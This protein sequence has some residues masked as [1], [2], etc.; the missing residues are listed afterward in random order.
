MEDSAVGRFQWNRLGAIS[1][2][3]FLW[4]TTTAEGCRRWVSSAPPTAAPSR[5]REQKQR[6]QNQQNHHHQQQ[7]TVSVFWDLDNKPPKRVSPFEAAIRLKEMAGR[8][9]D[10]VDLVAYANHHAFTYVPTWIHEERRQRKV[11]DLL[12]STG[13]VKPNEPYVC[14]VCGAKK[15]THVQLTKHFKMLHEREQKKRMNRL[16]SLKAKKK[17]KERFLENNGERMAK[18]KEAA[19]GIVHPKVGYGLMQDIRRAGVFVRTVK[20]EPQAADIALKEHMVRS[21]KRGVHCICLVSDDTDFK[22]ELRMAKERRLHTVVVGDMKILGAY[23]DTYFS[24]AE[25]ASG[26][27]EQKAK[28]IN[29]QLVLGEIPSSESVLTLG[30]YEAEEV[31]EEEDSEWGSDS[32]GDVKWIRVDGHDR[33][34][35]DDGFDPFN[36]DFSGSDLEDS[37]MDRDGKRQPKLHGGLT[38]STFGINSR[39]PNR[40]RSFTTKREIVDDEESRNGSSSSVKKNT[41]ADESNTPKPERLHHFFTM[42]ESANKGHSVTN[43]TPSKK[44]SEAG[45]EL[46]TRHFNR[47]QDILKSCPSVKEKNLTGDDDIRG[48]KARQYEGLE[49]DVLDFSMP[50]MEAENLDS[51]EEPEIPSSSGSDYRVDNSESVKQKTRRIHRRTGPGRAR[52]KMTR[53]GPI[54][55]T[56]D[57]PRSFHLSGF[58][59]ESQQDCNAVNKYYAKWWR[60]ETEVYRG[61]QDRRRKK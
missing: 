44:R 15:K 36:D 12:E 18:Y 3:G 52:I 53:S 29:G 33:E 43:A 9:G 48:K 56:R 50:E 21:I 59:S 27:A 14:R 19:R 39:V 32:D 4:E 10:V 25:V 24:W 40:G 1:R 46:E 51:N 5:P 57:G 34:I 23:A 31:P 37:E 22:P 58:A 6:Q 60:D 11:L 16:D 42:L 13:E 30:E 45:D 2:D 20:D 8:F 35:W 7:R 17:Q 55:V 47:V 28:I 61:R 41:T 38:R 49:E 54:K 26:R